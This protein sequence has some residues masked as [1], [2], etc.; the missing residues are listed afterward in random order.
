MR[1]SRPHAF[2]MLSSRRTGSA[3]RNWTGETHGRAQAV[4]FRGA[5]GPERSEQ[6]N[7]FLHHRGRPDATLFSPDN[8]PAIVTT[9]GAVE[10]WTIENRA[11]ENHEFHI[12]QIHFLLLEQNGVPVNNGQYL[13]TIQMP[14]WSGTGP[15][16]SVKV[17]MDFRGPLIGDFVYH[18][19]I[20]GHEDAGMMAIIRVKPLGPPASRRLSLRRFSRSSRSWLSSGLRRKPE[21]PDLRRAAGLRIQIVGRKDHDGSARIAGLRFPIADGANG[22][23]AIHSRHVHVHEHDVETPL[24]HQIDGFQGHCAPRQTDSRWSRILVSTKLSSESSATRTFRA[25]QSLLE[26]SAARR[27]SASVRQG[28]EIASPMGD[29]ASHWN[30]AVP[31]SARICFPAT[32]WRLQRARHRHP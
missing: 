14:Y 26:G 16:P 8:P 29:R 32:R 25:A 7:E 18:C 15:Y 27:G 10:D 21:Q 3:S 13:D 28:S 6:P 22:F 30:S 19:H 31:P 20:L 5:L 17:R 9:Q 4:F 11:L 23:V 12:H 2:P 1:P 24:L